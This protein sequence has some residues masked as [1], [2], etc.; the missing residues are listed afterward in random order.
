MNGGKKYYRIGE[1]SQILG[2][3]P[4]VLRYWETEFPEIRPV[5]GKSKHRHYSQED[6]ETLRFIKQLLYEEGYTIKGAKVKLKEFLGKKE[7]PDLSPYLERI[8]KKL[9][10]TKELLLSALRR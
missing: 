9:K 1:A 2:V 4:H 3:K 5:K 8:E 6:M 10:E 7:K